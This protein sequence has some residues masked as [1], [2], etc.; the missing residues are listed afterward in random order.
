M[1]LL[2][3]QN[4]QIS[5]PE[6]SALGFQ[7]KPPPAPNSWHKKFPDFIHGKKA[8]LKPEVLSCEVE[9]IE[10]VRFTETMDD[11]DTIYIAHEYLTTPDKFINLCNTITRSGLF[12]RSTPS[13]N[14]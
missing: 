3:L 7:I 13:F 5:V 9:L 14:F 6:F 10:N 4:K 1:Q 11:L 8:Q 12:L 2:C